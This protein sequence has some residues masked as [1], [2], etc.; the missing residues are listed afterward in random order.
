MSASCSTAITREDTRATTVPPVTSHSSRRATGS[1]RCPSAAARS[2]FALSITGNLSR[3]GR[4]EE[5]SAAEPRLAAFASLEDALDGWRRRDERCYQV[6]AGLT[7]LGSRRGGDDDDAALA[8]VVL[9]EG[10]VT[11]VA[12]T[13]RDLCEVD[14]VIATVWEE[15]KAAEPQLGPRAARYLLQRARQRLSRPAAGMVS[16]VATT[17]L[18]QRLETSSTGAVGADSAGA[19]EDLDRDLLLAVPDVE[20]PVADLVDLLTWA[21]GTGVVAAEEVRLIVE[22][23]AAEG[24]GLPRE[25]AQRLI[26]ERHGVGMRTIRRRRDA[27][28]ARLRRA[29]PTYLSDIA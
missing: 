19:G 27:T 10:G 17:S 24:D 7:A 1:A 5:W 16:R 12:M 23:L 9:L 15:V 25:A 8:V 22:L 13:L 2:L 11:R 29:A 20:D 3:S 21:T 18:E 26:G 6:V 4:W 14:D 28:A